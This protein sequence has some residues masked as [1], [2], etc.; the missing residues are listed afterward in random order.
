MCSA[1]LR[2]SGVCYASRA[3]WEACTYTV[4][5][6]SRLAFSFSLSLSYL[7]AV[8]LFLAGMNVFVYHLKFVRRSTKIG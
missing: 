1:I 7:I 3:F 8:F 4:S 6:A 2:T 5:Q